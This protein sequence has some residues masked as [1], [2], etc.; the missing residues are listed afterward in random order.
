MGIWIALNGGGF[1]AVPKTGEL[2]AISLKKAGSEAR[3]ADTS[4]SERASHLTNV[5]N[6]WPGWL[7]AR[8]ERVEILTGVVHGGRGGVY[9]APVAGIVF[10]LSA[11][12][13][14]TSQL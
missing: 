2:L 4:G 12:D 8:I 14:L 13:A 5:G 1:S 10:P 7:T 9:F 3:L 11:S 6:D